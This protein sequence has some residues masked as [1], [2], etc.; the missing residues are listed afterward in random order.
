MFVLNTEVEYFTKL[1]DIALSWVLR[2]LGKKKT[3]LRAYS[4]KSNEG[5]YVRNFGAITSLV[6][7]IARLRSGGVIT[8]SDEKEIQFE[9]KRLMYHEILALHKPDTE[10]GESLEDCNF[11]NHIK[12]NISIHQNNK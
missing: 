7:Q 1:R 11:V 10:K 9:V 5:G 6:N 4:G 2:G 3:D 8:D 12:E